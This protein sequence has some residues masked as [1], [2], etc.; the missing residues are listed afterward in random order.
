MTMGKEIIEEVMG[1]FEEQANKSKEDH[2]IFRESESG[3]VRMLGIWMGHK[4]DKNE[5]AKSM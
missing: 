2:G 5:T 3:N 4:K 1:N